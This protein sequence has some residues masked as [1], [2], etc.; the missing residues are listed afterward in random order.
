MA[1]T[2]LS[3]SGLVSRNNRPSQYEALQ[4]SIPSG[5]QDPIQHADGSHVWCFRA[6]VQYA[7]LV[8]GRRERA[9]GMA[10]GKN[11]GRK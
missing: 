8:E 2:C 7:H 6:R 4:S 3:S 11:V 1:C 9:N 5:L 10:V